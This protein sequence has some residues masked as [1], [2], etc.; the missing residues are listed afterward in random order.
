MRWG[1]LSYWFEFLK[2][3]R[4][5]PASCRHASNHYS[6]LRALVD[7]WDSREQASWTWR[8]RR[9]RGREPRW[10]LQGWR[11]GGLNPVPQRR[12][13]AAHPLQSVW[14]SFDYVTHLMIRIRSLV[15]LGVLTVQAR[16]LRPPQARVSQ[17]WGVERSCLGR[18]GGQLSE[19]PGT[20]GTSGSSSSSNWS[21]T[22]NRSQ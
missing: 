18:L 11:V 12:G 21:K 9:S 10:K 1:Y 15:T 13:K 20:S 22:E 19:L 2:A 5:Y 17:T 16:S 6:W 14:V 8:R 3:A 4:I 7:P